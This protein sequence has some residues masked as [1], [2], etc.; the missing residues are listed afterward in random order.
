MSCN[1]SKTDSEVFSWYRQ[2]A[3]YDPRRAMAVR[4]WI[5]GDLRLATRL[6]QWAEPKKNQPEKGLHK[7]Q[8]I[9]FDLEAAA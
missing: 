6:L 8:N 7:L 3:F 1:G 2:Q 4:A 9:D 5:D